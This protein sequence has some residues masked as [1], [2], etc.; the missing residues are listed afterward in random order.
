MRD[1]FKVE[2]DSV[3]SLEKSDAHSPSPHRYSSRQE[4]TLFPKTEWDVSKR[5]GGERLAITW[6]FFPKL[7]DH[8]KACTAGSQATPSWE[9][10]LNSQGCF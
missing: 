10:L 9:G 1:S 3:S 8:L 7:A 4:R 5:G 2:R 6:L